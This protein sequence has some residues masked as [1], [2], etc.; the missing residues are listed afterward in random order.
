MESGLL[1]LGQ[2]AGH[3][4][5][6]RRRA[7]ALVQR[8]QLPAERLGWQ[9]F[10]SRSAIE[11]AENSRVAK[12]GRPLG[13]ESA[14]RL[15]RSVC[16][17]DAHLAA[18]EMD[19]F[20]RRVHGRADHRR[21]YVH[22]SVVREL[23]SDAAVVV[24]GADAAAE[25][26]A[27]LDEPQVHDVYVRAADADRLNSAFAGRPDDDGNI[28]L[29]AV[30]DRAWPFDEGQR[31]APAWVA[32]LDLEDRRERGADLLLDRLIGGRVLA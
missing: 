17:G 19:A 24:S 9:W 26:G 2:V 15:I 18:R 21:L 6:S 30:E 11:R 20:R 5:V 1:T 27:P 14:W 3:L 12:P 13:A 23:L 4:G 25:A 29:H 22:P 28:A 31:F 16:D 7:Q 8:G 32:W 10:V